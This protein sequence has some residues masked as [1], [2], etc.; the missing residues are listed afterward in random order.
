MDE[1]RPNL[2]LLG[3]NLMENEAFHLNHNHNHNQEKRKCSST[4]SNEQDFGIYGVHQTL[5]ASPPTPA[6]TPGRNSVGTTSAVGQY[7]TLQS[8]TKSKLLKKYSPFI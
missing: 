4:S 3:V 6:A 5:E 2:G 7:H 1:L 8:F